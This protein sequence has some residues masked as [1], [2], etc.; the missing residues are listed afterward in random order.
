M[1]GFSM[2]GF[3]SLASIIVSALYNQTIISVAAIILIIALLALF[4]I[5]WIPREK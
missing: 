5:F 3:S 4:T 2:T 1:L